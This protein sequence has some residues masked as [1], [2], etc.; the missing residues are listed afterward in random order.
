MFYLIRNLTG[1]S[2]PR[3]TESPPIRQTRNDP[4]EPREPVKPSKEP[5]NGIRKRSNK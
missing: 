1:L 3:R 5:K 2:P 4:G